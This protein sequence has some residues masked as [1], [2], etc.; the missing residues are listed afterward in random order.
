MFSS[1]LALGLL[2][3]PTAMAAGGDV[4]FS[5][6]G[7]WIWMDQSEDLNSTW[8]TSVRLGQGLGEHFFVEAQTTYGQG[9]SRIS[10]E[11]ISGDSVGNY[12][13]HTYSPRIEALVNLAPDFALQPTFGIGGGAIYKEVW[14]DRNV[15]EIVQ[16]EEWFGNHK[17]PDFDVLFSAGPGFFLHLFGPINLRTDFRFIMTAGGEA[18][19]AT[20]GPDTH[21]HWEIVSGLT[22]KASW[23]TRDTDE[24]GIPDNEDVCPNEPED[25]D[26]FED[27]EGCPDVDNDQDNIPDTEDQCMHQPEDFDG[28]EDRDGCPELDNDQDG[29][30]D[31]EDSCPNQREDQDGFEDDDGC[32]EGDNDDDGIADLDDRC[33]TQK[34]DID[35]FEDDDGCPDVDNDGDQILDVNDACP[36]AAEDSD[37]FDDDDGCPEGDNDGDGIADLDDQCPSQVEDLDGFEDTD[38]CPD[39][40]ND[41]DQILDVEDQCPNQAEV[42]NNIEDD[43]GC[44][45]EIPAELRRFTGVIHGINFRTNSDE[46][47]LTSLPLLDEAATV[48]INYPGIQMEVQG[49]TDS[50]GPDE[51]NLDLSARR[52]GSV[53]N[54]L[55]DRGVSAEHLTWV[56]YGETRPLYPNNSEEEKEA[57]RRVEFHMTNQDELLNGYDE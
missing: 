8:V 54:Y 47:K 49:H 42:I 34:E 40:D 51:Y 44:P 6:G 43:D 14:A 38:G 36:N 10:W 37:G 48:L 3:S 46:L 2:S 39:A 55:I 17:N 25:Y 21:A 50:D 18:E 11:D 5:A 27:E 16:N 13:Y 45:D 9:R 15:T 12:I 1:L 24:D 19:A 29:F 7:G 52:A 57:N 31:S 30:M 20:D 4:L 26:T 28:F 41:G 33:P 32:P 35:G 23:F 53:V 22:F 56:G